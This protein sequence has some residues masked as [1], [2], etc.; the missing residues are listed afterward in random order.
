MPTIPEIHATTGQYN[1]AGMINWIISNP[2]YDLLYGLP[3]VENTTESIRMIGQEITSFAPRRNQFNNAL[4]NMIGLMRITYMLFTNPLA[5][6]K[7]GKLEMGETVEQIFVGQA[8]VFPFNPAE[9]ETRFLK[10]AL[11]EVSTAFHSINFHDVYKVTISRMELKRAF[12]SLDGLVNL[13]EN[14]MGSLERSATADEFMLMKYLISTLLLAGKINAQVIEPITKTSADDVAME[15]AATSNLF[16]F[17][18]TEYNMAGVTNTTPISNLVIFESARAN[19]KL[20]VFSLANAFN[21][22]YVKFIGQV[23]MFDSLGTYDWKR[24]DKLLAGDK[25]YRRFTTDEINLLNSIDLIVMDRNFLQIYDAE[26]EMEIPLYNGEGAF[27]NY[28]YHVASIFSASPFHNVVAFTTEEGSV[29]S[30][31]VSPATATLSPGGSIGFQAD[32]V[33]TGFASSSIFWEISTQGVADGTYI[34]QDAILHV[35]EDETVSEITVVATSLANE[36]V[37]G[38]A[39]VTVE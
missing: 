6:M 10:R 37:T 13:I 8:E 15:V 27:T 36:E 9:S 39:T 28:F 34:G 24:M 7:K 11:G 30:I 17:P 31:T 18:S 21:V 35:A 3:Q 1:S 20:K 29:E 16:Q 38:S 23:K 33:T 22:D 5:D 12:L 26:R 14:K 2:E 4:I 32:V 25:G 19:A